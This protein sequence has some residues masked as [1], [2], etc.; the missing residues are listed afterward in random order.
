M[1]IR[2]IAIRNAF[3]EYLRVKVSTPVSMMYVSSSKVVAKQS[4]VTYNSFFSLL[5]TTNALPFIDPI[6]CNMVTPSSKEIPNS[7]L[8]PVPSR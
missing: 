7:G 3:E 4:M 2:S 5:P 6:W 8:K 1:V